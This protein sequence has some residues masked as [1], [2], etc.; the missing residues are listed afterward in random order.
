MNESEQGNAGRTGDRPVAARREHD[1]QDGGHVVATVA[2]A[3]ADAENGEPTELAPS[4][5]DCVDP[6]ALNSLFGPNESGEP[7]SAMGRVTFEYRDYE[8]AV[9]SG[10]HV[11]V[12]E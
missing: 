8:V 10:G 12:Y 5:Y 6:S 2:E 9:T 1:W 7:R 11:I 3:L 4:L